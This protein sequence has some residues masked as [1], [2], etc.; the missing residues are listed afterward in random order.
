MQIRPMTWFEWLKEYKKNWES[1]HLIN[2]FCENPD[3]IITCHSVPFMTE[4][5]LS[6]M[7][8]YIRSSGQIDLRNLHSLIH[9]RG[10]MLMEY[11]VSQGAN[12]LDCF[13]SD[14]LINLYTRHGFKIVRKEPNWVSGEPNV[15]WMEK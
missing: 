8:L 3:L 10:D 9:G 15:V 13:E 5:K 14:H 4:D 1:H 12:S 2:K 11:A 6:G 7:S